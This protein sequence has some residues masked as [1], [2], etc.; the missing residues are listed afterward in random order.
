M[1]YLPPM[2]LHSIWKGISVESVMV[3]YAVAAAAVVY[4]MIAVDGW[5]QVFTL[6]YLPAFVCISIVFDRE[7]RITFV[8][9]MQLLE[10]AED[11][12]AKAKELEGLV[13]RPAARLYPLSLF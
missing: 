9:Q 1:M 13:S 7:G 10:A 8:Q 2:L 5:G 12:V 3:G 11:A 4:A 6:L